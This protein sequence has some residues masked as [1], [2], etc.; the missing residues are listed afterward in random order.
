MESVV[1]AARLIGLDVFTVVSGCF[2]VLWVALPIGA[3]LPPGLFERCKI[4][5]FGSLLTIC[6]PS[7]ADFVVVPFVGFNLASGRL[8]A[9]TALS[10]VEVVGL[11][12][13]TTMA[14]VSLLAACSLST[15]LLAGFS[16]DSVAVVL[17]LAPSSVLLLSALLDD[18]MVS[19]LTLENTRC[20][21]ASVS[22]LCVSDIG[23]EL[24]AG[25]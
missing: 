17:L 2:G 16:A 15:G 10:V 19:A 22:S 24:I 18:F 23:A 1:S 13:A 6:A 20:R 4:A 5:S 12:S 25:G 9:F 11:P 8:D 21:R 14:I 7:E 3:G